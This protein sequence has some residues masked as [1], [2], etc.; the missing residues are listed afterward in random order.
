M[1]P[2]SFEEYAIQC[3]SGENCALRTVDLACNSGLATRCGQER[4]QSSFPF[5]NNTYLP[6]RDQSKAP[7]GVLPPGSATCSSAPEPSA[8]FRKS[9]MLSSRFELNRICL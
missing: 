5:L 6:S 2:V 4:Y 9:W 3:P 8:F 1:L 7:A